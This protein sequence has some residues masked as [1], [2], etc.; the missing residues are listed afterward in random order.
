MLGGGEG[1]HEPLQQGDSPFGPPDAALPGLLLVLT[2][3]ELV[4]ASIDCASLPDCSGLP[5]YA[6]AV[7]AIGVPCALFVSIGLQNVYHG[8]SAHVA[9]MSAF[10]LLWWIVGTFVMTF[11][12]PFVYLSN[13]Y[14][15]AWAALFV[16]LQLCRRQ[17]QWEPMEGGLA[18][19]QTVVRGPTGHVVLLLLSSTVMW[20][21]AASI[22]QHSIAQ[23]SIA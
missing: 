22:A 14:F 10:L 12:G 6:V 11:C 3:C 23:H 17:T 15:A 2:V 18:W 20:V 8:V 21:E 1:R 19:V 16:T 13:G 9:H 4:A 7:G 5:A